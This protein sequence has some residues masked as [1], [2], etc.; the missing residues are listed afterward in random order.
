[1]GWSDFFYRLISRVDHQDKPPHK[2]STQYLKAFRSYP[3]VKLARG[4]TY[5]THARECQYEVNFSSGGNSSMY[6]I[7]L[8]GVMFWESR[9]FLSIFIYFYPFLI[10]LTN[11]PDFRFLRFGFYYIVAAKPM[12]RFGFPKHQKMYRGRKMVPCEFRPRP[13]SAPDSPQL[14]HGASNEKWQPFAP[15]PPLKKSKHVFRFFSY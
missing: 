6:L 13:H 7:V 14:P 10:D 11:F 4:H 3:I 9:P 5:D 1:M 2:I 15:H 8:G 12:V